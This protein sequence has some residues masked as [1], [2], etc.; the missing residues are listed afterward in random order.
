SI[1]L[2]SVLSFPSLVPPS[3]RLLLFLLSLHDA[4]PISL[5]AVVAMTLSTSI[6]TPLNP[7]STSPMM[8]ASSFRHLPRTRTP[9]TITAN[10]KRRSEEHTSELQSRFDLVCRLLLAKKKRKPHIY[11][12]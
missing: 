4:L 9:L 1:T 11:Q 5:L 6:R 10:R 3:L 12:Q 2:S 8:Y 7:P